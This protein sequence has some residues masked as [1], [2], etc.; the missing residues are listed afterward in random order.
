MAYERRD[1]SGS[2]VETT[3][4]GSLGAGDTSISIAASTG[5]PDGGNGK[6]YA[7]IDPGTSSEE[8]VLITS[9]SGTTLS[10]VTRGADGTSAVSHASGATI[11]HCFSAVDHD[12]ANYWVA[13]LAGAAG[14]ASDLIIADADNS[15]SRIPK[16]SSSRVLAVDGDGTLGYTTVTNAMV[17]ASA[18]LSL[19]K[20]ESIADQRFLGNVSGGSA[21]PSA[22]TAAQL[23]TALGVITG[24]TFTT[25]RKTSDESVTSNTT[26][27]DDDELT[28]SATNGV[29]FEVEAVLVYAS[30]VGGGTPDFKVQIHDGGGVDGAFVV[31]YLSTS[32]TATVGVVT[33]GATIAAGTAAGKRVVHFRGGFT[34]GGSA[35]T[36]QWAQNTS[37]GNA[38]TV[39]AGSVLRYRAL[40]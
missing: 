22:L 29:A 15:L 38:T 16:G 28:F 32:D 1:F 17:V 14:A 25:I 33:N 11:R 26:V 24:N 20:L 7:V 12:E 9:R 27:Q 4:S 2:A 40:S 19:S 23:Q 37:N 34:G 31:T 36:V 21:A 39:Y 10:S 30:P 5:W 6:F 8:K 35:L 13:E 3:D 18:G